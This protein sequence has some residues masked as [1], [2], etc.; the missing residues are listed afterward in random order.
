M[1]KLLFVILP[2]L[3][4]LLFV[5]CEDSAT[6]PI[7]T[8]TTGSILVTSSPV[9]A[10]IWVNN[11]ATGKVTP[12]SVTGLDAGS[13]NITLKLSGYRDTTVSVTV[14]AGILTPKHVDMTQNPPDLESY[15]GI[16]LYERQS[17]NLSGLDLSTG[18]RTG[19]GV[20]ETDVY[21][22]GVSGGSNILRSQHL[23]TPAPATL[24]YTYFYNTSSSSLTDGADSP[25]YTSG[26]WNTETTSSTNYSFLYDSDSHY[27]KIKIVNSGQDGPFDRWIEV[28]YIYDKTA[29]DVRF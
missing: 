15:S 18:T 3:L 12:D 9:G 17:N 19:S 6:D 13:V 2:V 20:A 14:T 29:N 26:T 10:S 27:S 5:S 22:E 28:N 21:F 4:A 8:P 25:L 7:I 11:T 24:R 16:K 23:R 1:K